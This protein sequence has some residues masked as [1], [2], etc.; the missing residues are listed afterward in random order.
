MAKMHK[1]T[2][3]DASGGARLA[4]D[5]FSK[6]LPRRAFADQPVND[7]ALPGRAASRN[8]TP[9]DRGGGCF[10]PEGHDLDPI[11]HD[12]QMQCHDA[13]R[14]VVVAVDHEPRAQEMFA[15]LLAEP[16]NNRHP[17]IVPRMIHERLATKV[18][19]KVD[20]V[21]GLAQQPEAFLGRL[22]PDCQ[23]A[24]GG[25]GRGAG[26]VVIEEKNTHCGTCP[27]R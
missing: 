16:A 24:T 17:A 27:V 12:F 15:R 4:S 7:L 6:G 25:K 20:L 23:R 3:G 5:P 13:R 19:V 1:V 2:F 18:V 22:D 10:P 26:R 8:R 14:I 21:P 11:P 9:T